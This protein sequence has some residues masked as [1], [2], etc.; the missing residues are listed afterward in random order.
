MRINWAFIFIEVAFISIG[1]EII[2]TSGTGRVH[3]VSRFT[4]AVE[5][6]TKVV[7]D[8]IKHTGLK[9]TFIYVITLTIFEIE[10]V[11][12]ETLIGTDSV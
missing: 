5:A 10:S 8:R 7:T 12:T 6:S 2:I 4:R 9:I 1:T 3:L 11:L